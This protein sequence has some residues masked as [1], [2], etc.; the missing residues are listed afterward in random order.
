MLMEE[1]LAQARMDPRI[2]MDQLVKEEAQPPK[3]EEIL[4]QTQMLILQLLA[5]V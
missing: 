1:L 4:L 3:M 5:Q 2:R